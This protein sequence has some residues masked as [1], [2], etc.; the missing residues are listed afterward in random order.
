MACAVMAGCGG[1]PVT[2]STG[3]GS[4]TPAAGAPAG[5]GQHPSSRT[6]YVH[7]YLW[8]TTRHWNDKLGPAYPYATAPIP[9]AINP[10][11]CN[12]T[13]DYSGS[14]IVDVP[15][16][17]LYDQTQSET[18]VRHISLA[19]QAGLEGFLA[20]WQGTGSPVQ[21]PASS[22]YNSRLELLVTTVDAY[23]AEHA[24]AFGLGLAYAAF[25]DYSR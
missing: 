25:G 23:N 16:E 5:V 6:V 22:G 8:W 1:A 19:D 7:Y 4:P 10:V 2:S 12:P 21:S 17:G 13:V 18:F 24:S 11:G 3:A 9:G 14:Q 15:A 20:D